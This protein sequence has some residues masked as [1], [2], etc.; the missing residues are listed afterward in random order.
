MAQMSIGSG[1]NK[2]KRSPRKIIIWVVMLLV[3]PEL[4]QEEGNTCVVINKR[5]CVEQ[6]ALFFFFGFR[7]RELTLL[8]D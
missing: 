5:Y 6:N 8:S 2:P 1:E 3:L 7:M 4:G